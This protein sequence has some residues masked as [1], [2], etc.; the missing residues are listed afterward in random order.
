MKRISAWLDRHPKTRIALQLAVDGMPFWL[1]A[2]PFTVD[3]I[4]VNCETAMI[5]HWL[6]VMT[7]ASLMLTM[8]GGGAALFGLGIWLRSRAER[9]FARHPGWKGLSIAL[10]VLSFVPAVISAG[11]CIGLLYHY[12][13]NR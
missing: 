12:F 10:C 9:A 7:T 4:D 11:L 1:M 3:V 5:P 2:F 8:Y 6:D 13:K